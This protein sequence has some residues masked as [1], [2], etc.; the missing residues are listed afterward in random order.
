[1]KRLILALAMMVIVPP[2]WSQ[3]NNPITVEEMRTS[4]N[5]GGFGE[6][7]C[8]G[9][10]LGVAV[11]LKTNAEPRANPEGRPGFSM[12]ADDFVSSEQ[13]KQVFLNWAN[14]NP[15]HW[16]LHGPYGA[17]FALSQVFPCP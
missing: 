5:D 6:A 8:V 10:L 7:A 12:C 17:M 1:M 15:K 16:Q 13:M 2:A 11:V 4:C 14:A 3:S 9:I